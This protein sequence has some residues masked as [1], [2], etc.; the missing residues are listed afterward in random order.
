MIYFNYNGKIFSENEYIIGPA[1]RGLRYGDGIFETLKY[2]NGQIILAAEHFKRLWAG[3]EALE[4]T[5][6]IHFTAEKLLVEILSLIKKNKLKE[7]RVRVT[8]I[9]SDGGIYDPKN[10]TPN[11]IIEAIKLP[12][13]N[14]AL[15]IN[16]LQICIYE[17]AIKSIDTFSNLKTNNYLPYFM[18]AKFA[19][20]QHCNDA[21]ILNSKGN[22][23]DSTIANVFL[24]KNKVIYTA[25]LEEGC[26][27]GVMRRWLINT[28]KM[29]EYKVEET[30][31]SKNL[32]LEADEV[33]LSNSIYNIRWVSSIENKTYTN[34]EV[35]KMNEL[36]QRKYPEV[37]C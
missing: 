16:G 11:Y 2:K 26:V 33:F 1:N 31:V 15:N 34:T 3:M 19:K 17:A 35:Q 18:G 24:I 37:F 20:K 28:L 21:F 13:D 14:G 30:T 32:L 36:L 12:E 22:I 9:R 10:N 29:L 7:A 27:A 8:V 25:A 4:F 23:C 5:V 6:P